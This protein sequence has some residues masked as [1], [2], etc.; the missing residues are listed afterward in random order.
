MKGCLTMSHRWTAGCAL[1]LCCVTLASVGC[2]GSHPSRM[3]QA[4]FSSNAGADALATYD[5]NKD[6]KI[7]GEELFNC[8]SLKAAINQLDPNK[9]GEVT[10]AMIDARVKSW[11][12]TKISRQNFSCTVLRNGKPFADATV[13]FIPEKFLGPA[14]LPAKGKTGKT[15]IASISVQTTGPR[16]PAGIGPGFYRVVITKEG[17]NIP[18]KYSKEAT[19]TLGQE[20]ARD[21]EGFQNMKGVKFNLK[22]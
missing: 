7:S 3:E 12:D 11:I 19:T 22:F 20:I 16:D 5:T 6:G 4:K 1:V 8:P 15:G 10:A 21:A 13:T 17:T 18:D 2:W 14:V 9:T